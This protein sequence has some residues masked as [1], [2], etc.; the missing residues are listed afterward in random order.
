MTD[1]VIPFPLPKKKEDDDVVIE[2]LQAIS[3][4]CDRCGEILCDGFCNEL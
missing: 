4:P 2:F 3:I 1:N